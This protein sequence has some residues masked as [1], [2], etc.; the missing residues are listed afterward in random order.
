MHRFAT[1][2]LLALASVLALASTAEAKPDCFPR[3]DEDSVVLFETPKRSKPVVGG[4]LWNGRKFVPEA[5][6][7]VRVPAPRDF[8]RRL[9]DEAVEGGG[10]EDESAAS[11]VRQL[12][13]SI[14]EETRAAATSLEKIYEAGFVDSARGTAPRFPAFVADQIGGTFEAVVD[15]SI[16]QMEAYADLVAEVGKTASAFA[17]GELSEAERNDAYLA[18]AAELIDLDL[19]LRDGDCD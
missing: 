12:A 2:I 1:S 18:I 8:A 14:A 7:E 13:A 10:N 4:A 17:E 16:Q 19:A 15:Q 5:I 6:S 11:V 3:L 9:L